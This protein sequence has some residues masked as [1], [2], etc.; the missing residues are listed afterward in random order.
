MR[1][2]GIV[3]V[4]P[5][6]KF[7]PNINEAEKEVNVQAFV[8]E[9]AVEAFHEA[10]LDRPSRP[11][12][13]ELNPCL[14]DPGI[15]GPAAKLSAIVDGYG[16]RQASGSGEPLKAKDHLLARKGEVGPELQALTGILI[17]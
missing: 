13:I 7:F 10:V 8:P 16:H 5:G 3:V 4:T 2:Q 9:P 17:D 6:L 1:S 15:H 11:Y 14:V 12:K